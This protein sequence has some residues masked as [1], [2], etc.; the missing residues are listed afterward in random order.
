MTWNSS[1]NVKNT[2]PHMNL[3]LLKARIPHTVPCGYIRWFH[4]LAILTTKYFSVGLHF[5]V[6]FL[7]YIKTRFSFEP[8][9]NWMWT[10]FLVSLLAPK[11]TFLCSLLFQLPSSGMLEASCC[12][13]S[14][15]CLFDGIKIMC[16]YTRKRSW[17]IFRLSCVVYPQYH[18]LVK[19]ISSLRQMA[20][21][22]SVVF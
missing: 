14:N 8:K 22:I 16:S 11:F 10:Y 4:H 15:Q 7:S 13:G 6:W 17:R 12:F 20:T 19:R 3:C 21:T 9:H 18:I 2:L 5:N 1:C